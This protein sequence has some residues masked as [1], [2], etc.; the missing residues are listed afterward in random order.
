MYFYTSGIVLS[1]IA[2]SSQGYAYTVCDWIC[3]NGS[4]IHTSD[5]AT[6]KS[7]NFMYNWAIKPQLLVP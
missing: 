4:Y 3:E 2:V 5:F 6:L 1:L 7:Y